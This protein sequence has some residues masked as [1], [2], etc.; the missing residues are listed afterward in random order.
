[1]ES[2]LFLTRNRWVHDAILPQPHAGAFC[3]AIQT[4]SDFGLDPMIKDS[5][6]STP[7]L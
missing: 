2:Y 6:M 7:V 5:G 3:H 1:M 4:A